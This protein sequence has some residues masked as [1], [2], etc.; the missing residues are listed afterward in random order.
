MVLIMI[1]VL[2]C[3]AMM[4]R[5]ASFTVGGALG[6]ATFCALAVGVLLALFRFARDEDGV[7]S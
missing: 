4:L 5:V 7:E 1:P 6:A 3:V 2:A